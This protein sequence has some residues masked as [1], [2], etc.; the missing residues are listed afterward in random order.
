MNPTYLYFEFTRILRNRRV[1]MFSLV[2]PSVMLVFIGRAYGDGTVF[3]GVSGKAYFMVSMALLGVMANALSSGGTIAV[4]RGLGWNRQ[5]R[6]TPLRPVD[7]VI[8]KVLVALGI[9]A[10]PLLMTFLIGRLVLDIQLGAAV[11]ASMAGLVLLSALPFA[12]LG[13]AI[14]YFIKPESAQQVVGLVNMGLALLGG[15]WFPVTGGAM[16]TIAELTPTYWAG[17][18]ARGPLVHGHP[19]AQSLIVIA[20]WT[21]GL[22]AIAFR[23]FQVAT[24]RA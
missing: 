14:G 17:Q 11:W 8:T 20:A 19:S 21:V 1:L 6:L 13:V 2:L 23:R 4:E 12:A 24:E 7:Y 5:L 22:T 10:G 3:P 16:K 15:I 18:L 9:A